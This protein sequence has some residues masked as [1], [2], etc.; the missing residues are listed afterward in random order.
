MRN[1]GPGVCQVGVASLWASVFPPK[2]GRGTQRGLQGVSSAE[3]LGQCWLGPQ[4]VYSPLTH[5]L[6]TCLEGTGCPA[7]HLALL[8]PS[9]STAHLPLSVA[10]FNFVQAQSE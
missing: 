1:A 10:A 6:L 5:H 3:Y 9:R 8:L 2:P 7:F 4:A